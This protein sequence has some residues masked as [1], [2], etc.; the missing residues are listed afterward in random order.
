MIGNQV[1]GALIIS[2]AHAS[3]LQPCPIESNEN[4]NLESNHWCAHRAA[5]WDACG[6]GL[7]SAPVGLA[8]WS[9]ASQQTVSQDCGHS[10]R[11]MIRE[12]YSVKGCGWS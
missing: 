5:V 6:Q 12:A 2:L 7:A 3:T 4:K 8:E 10:T 9:A 1:I 11:N